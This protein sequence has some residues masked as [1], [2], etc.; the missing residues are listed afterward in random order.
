MCWPRRCRRP[1]SSP[2]AGRRPDGAD[3]SRD[4]HGL[5]PASGETTS[6][7]PHAVPARPAH[8]RERGDDPASARLMLVSAGS[9]PRAGRRRRRVLARR[10]HGRLIPASGETTRRGRG[11]AAASRA[12]PRERG[13]DAARGVLHDVPHGSSPR[14]GRRPAAAGRRCGSGGL[15]PASGETTSRRRRAARSNPA[16]PRERGDDA[17]AARARSGVGGSSPRAGRRRCADRGYADHR[18][19][20]PASGETTA[21]ETRGP[22]EP[23]AHPRERGDDSCTVPVNTGGRGSS[24]RAGRRLRRRDGEARVPRLIPASGETTR[25]KVQAGTG[26]AAHP[27]E[28]GDDAAALSV[29]AVGSGSSPRAGRRPGRVRLRLAHTGLIPASGE[30]T[31]SPRSP[32]LRRTAHPRERGDDGAVS[33]DVIRREGSSPRAGRRQPRRAGHGRA[34]RLIPASGETT[35]PRRSRSGRWRAHPRERGDDLVSRPVPKP[36]WGSSPRA[37][38]RRRQ[39]TTRRTQRGLIPASGETTGSVSASASSSAAHPRERGDD[40]GH[41]DVYSFPEGSSPRAGRRPGRRRTGRP[42]GGLI[43]ASGETTAPCGPSRLR[44]AAHP[45][46]RGDDD[47]DDTADHPDAGSSPRAGRRLRLA[48]GETLGLR[49]IP[50]SGETTTCRRH[51]VIGEPGSSPRAGRRRCDCH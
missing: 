8:P 15:I 16:H 35:P 3:R 27:R 33:C 23:T 18:G 19:L 7:P 49:L 46:E 28:R 22:Q 4:R 39:V 2:R 38:R 41:M 29:A 43:P 10:R 17:C 45:R 31:A 48:G 42:P 13:D 44:M 9:S 6:P 14:A 20:I 21:D 25:C 30:T 12:H 34:A 40:E 26:G 50:A 36:V 24:P 51:D 5:I 11:R 1:G 47:A 37:G 32:P